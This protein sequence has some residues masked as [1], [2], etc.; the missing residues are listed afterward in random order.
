MLVDC[1]LTG[2]YMEEE[3]RIAV[4]RCLIPAAGRGTIL[5]YKGCILLHV[6]RTNLYFCLDRNILLGIDFTILN[7]RIV[8]SIGHSK[9]RC[10]A[11]HNYALI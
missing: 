3:R 4:Q 1:Q 2:F 5:M 10:I 9:Y 6:F 11:S 8:R 7:F